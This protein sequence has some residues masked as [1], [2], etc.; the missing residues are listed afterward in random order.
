MVKP[1]KNTIC[2]WY[3]KDAEDAARFYAQTFPDSAVGAAYRAPSDYPSGK[4]GDVL[5]VEFTVA[6]V[7]C[8]GLNGGPAFTHSGRFRFRL[9]RRTRPRLTAIGM[10]L[11][12]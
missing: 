7:S 10:P 5:M 11:S 12:A 1:A 8:V 4:K 3:D 2:I 6:G 9:R